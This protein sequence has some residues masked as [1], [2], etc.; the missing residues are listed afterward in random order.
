MEY[1]AAQ[2]VK[3]VPHPLASARVTRYIEVD[4][5]LCVV[6][7][8]GKPI[9]GVAV[10]RPV[11]QVYHEG[12]VREAY[13]DT[14]E[15]VPVKPLPPQTVRTPRK[16]RRPTTF[17]NNIVYSHANSSRLSNAYK[18]WGWT[19]C[20]V[21]GCTKPVRLHHIVPRREGG[22]NEYDNLLPICA[23]HEE[24]L[25]RAGIAYRRMVGKALGN[26]KDSLMIIRQRRAE[27]QHARVTEKAQST[28]RLW[29]MKVGRSRA[30][31]AYLLWSNGA[32]FE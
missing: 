30:D 8:D 20:V 6:G 2:D 21:P 22:G 31:F 13:A 14:K 9:Q 29:W 23:G 27:Q 3:H 12:L 5:V 26:R 24:P 15:L 11:I 18:H 28:D 10:R 16:P 17:K 1:L 32:M 19:G 7:K 25:H 4:G